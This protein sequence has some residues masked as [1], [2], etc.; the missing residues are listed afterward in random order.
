MCRMIGVLLNLPIEE[1]K[2]AMLGE[3]GA[4]SMLLNLPIEEWKPEIRHDEGTERL[5]L[6]SSY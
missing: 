4:S 6:E 1:W 3:R 5:P 2:R